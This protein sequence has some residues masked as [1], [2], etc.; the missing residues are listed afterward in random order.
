MTYDWNKD[1]NRF[2]IAR[3]VLLQIVD[4]IY[5]VNNEVEFAVRAYGVDYPA[6]EKNCTDSR[7]IV[8]FNLQNVNQIKQSLKYTTAIGWSPIAFS[9]E[10]AAFGEINNTAAYDYSIIFITDGGE[11]CG[12]DICKTFAE[13]LTKK[14]SVTPYIIGL[15]KNEQLKSY[16]D[17]LGKYVPVLST[18]DVPKAVKLIVD[19]NRPILEK[20][21][22]LDLTT[23]FSNSPIKKDTAAVITKVIPPPVKKDTVPVAKID[24]VK[25]I[26]PPKP[27]K[28]VTSVFPRLEP[29]SALRGVLTR[30]RE[31]PPMANQIA[32]KV[33]Y[34]FA[35]EIEQ[36]KL[37]LPQLARIELRKKQPPSAIPPARILPQS[38]LA[39]KIEYQFEDEIE[40]REVITLSEL[41]PFAARYRFVY[42]YRVPQ[43]VAA[44]PIFTAIKYE[45]TFT[46]IKRDTIVSMLSPPK[47]IDTREAGTKQEANTNVS[48]EVVPNDETMVQVFFI[49]KFQRNKMY[50]GATPTI[51]VQDAFTNAD[52]TQFIRSTTSGTPDMKPIKPGVYNFIVKGDNRIVTPNVR[53]DANNINKV[54]IEVTDGTIEF[55]Y[56]GNLKRPVKEFQAIV[57][58]RFENTGKTVI[59]ECKDKLYYSPGTYYIEINTVP[60][61]KFAMVELD[62]GEIRQIQIA[63]AGF[64]QINNTTRLGKVD[65][66]QPLNDDYARFETLTINGNITDQK[67]TMQPGTYQA[68]F[69]RDPQTPALGSKTISFTVKSNET[70]QLFLE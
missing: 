32:S 48:R 3:D 51:I 14:V 29:L 9:L 10:K 57:N 4:S 44:D 50:M 64:L 24:T 55:A 41:R 52:V 38:F 67:L 46:P 30:P 16:Y 40:K 33:E 2:G 60:A 12:G 15:D 66:L 59:Q 28:R 69:A 27:P 43:M 22:V 1:Y 56:I 21:K 36:V 35:D 42:A 20:K 61:T 49:N 58:P 25:K 45:F 31:I 7:L 47:Q 63:E 65:L 19:E 53:I 18:A 26:D 6:Q 23:V 8:P 17:C 11:S 62:F 70:T 54:Y 5:A 68:T 39:K 13:L 37:I 34:V